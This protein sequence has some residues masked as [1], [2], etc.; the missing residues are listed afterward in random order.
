ML[1]ID[2]TVDCEGAAYRT[3]VVLDIVLIVLYQG[4]PIIWFIVLFNQRALLNPSSVE[5]EREK[6]KKR[7]K[8]RQK[9][10]DAGLGVGVGV[11]ISSGGVGGTARSR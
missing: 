2:P 1:E 10:D 6:E 11:G 5:T 8:K 4:V 7:E 3:F 9:R